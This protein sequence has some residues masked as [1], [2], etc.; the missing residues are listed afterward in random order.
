[1]RI[2][3]SWLQELVEWR[4]TVSE[5]SSLLVNEGIE[6]E[7]IEEVG[8]HTEAIVTA[9]VIEVMPHPAAD[10]LA[11]CTVYDGSSRRQ[12]VCGAP[13][14]QVGQLVAL[15]LPGA[16]L[17]NGQVLDSRKIRGIDSQGMLCSESELGIGEDHSGIVVL[18]EKIGV[19]VPLYKV[20]P[21]DVVL[22]IGI[23]P[24]RADALSH[25]GVARI[26]AAASGCTARLPAVEEIQA[27]QVIPI[28]IV[29]PD[30]CPR[31]AGAL[32]EG[33]H[34]YP[35]PPWLARRL[36]LAGV[37]SRNLIVDVTNYVMLE[38][39]QPLHAFDYER[40]AQGRIVVRRAIQN[41]RITTLDG[42]ERTL[43]SETLCICDAERPQA[44]AGIMGGLESAI[45]SETRQVLIESAYF[46]PRN[47]RRTAKTLGLHTDAAYRFERGTDVEMVP[48]ALRRA[49]TLI[50][51]LSNA[52]ITH[53]ADCYPRPWKEPTVE[54]RFDHARRVLGMD[55]SRSTFISAIAGRGFN[56]ISEGEK[57]LTVRVPS[58][59][60][61]VRSEIDLIE[62]VAIGVGYDTVPP[63]PSVTLSLSLDTVPAPLE[64]SPVRQDV[65]QYLAAIGFHEALSYNLSDP[66]T[67]LEAEKAVEIANALGRERSVLRQWLLP[68]MVEILSR[69]A[70]CGVRIIRVFEIGKVFR[71]E[72]TITSTGIPVTEEEHLCIALAG[73]YRERHWLEPS[74]P[75]DFFDLKSAVEG[76]TRRFRMLCQWRVASRMSHLHQWLQDPVVEILLDGQVIGY[77]GS[78]S[79]RLLRQYDIADGAVVAELSMKPFYER[80]IQWDHYQP[81]S[82][83]PTVVRDIAVVVDST[84]PSAALEATI[85]DAIGELVSDVAPFDV[86]EHP[87]LGEGKKSIAFTLT[88]S[89][90]ERTLT[91]EEVNMAVEQAVKA[92]ASAYGAVLRSSTTQ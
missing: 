75:V 77:A 87:G 6:V 74:R 57:G 62:E 86:F 47:I 36:Q 52:Q 21:P 18:D 88:F 16:R 49:A 32:L 38:C 72:H 44:V 11:V 33:V 89:S 7:A 48:Y 1:M 53:W 71:Q 84:I 81:P 66:A 82:P 23:T 69:N 91:D 13:N 79:P 35:S 68:T 73:I 61:D 5:L 63:S 54:F 27:Q 83:F 59:R 43:D 70:R 42:V 41:E 78:I 92:L 8:I 58:F 3:L 37:R 50:A 17:P 39:G 29:E 64:V 90:S 19:G 56:I 60:H 4:G 22:E 20:Y 46:A 10:H 31:Y 40:L 55:I 26:I 14:V 25:Y 9:Q 85:R 45:S 30:L 67:L 51:R 15:A 28:E 65:R 76:L 80:R 34:P 12:V 24:N 2:V